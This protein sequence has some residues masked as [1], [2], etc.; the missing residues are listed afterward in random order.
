[1]I[2]DTFSTSLDTSLS[3][4][5]VV[6]AINAVAAQTG[7]VAT[8]TGDDNLGVTLTSSDGRNIDLTVTGILSNSLGLKNSASTVYVGSYSLY[9][10]DSSDITIG[11]ATGDVGTNA[12]TIERNSGLQIG[13]Y[14]ADTALFSSGNR[15]TTTA[16]APPDDSTTSG[17]LRSN[18]LI[19]N[20]VAIAAGVSTD[21]S[22]TWEGLVAADGTDIL[23]GTATTRAASA[24]AIAG[25]INRASA[26]TGVN[27]T[28]AANVIR[29]TGFAATG[30]AVTGHGV[31]LNG[32]SFRV[33]ATSVDQVID[34]FNDFKDQTGVVASRFGDGMQLVANDGRTISIATSASAASSLGLTG[35]TIGV[36]SV[37][38]TAVV[39]HYA[40]VNLSSDKSFEIKAGAGGN[41]NL[42]LLGFRQ[43]TYGASKNGMKI[44]DVDVS[45]AAGAN[46]SI[47]AI[48]SAINTV[49]AAQAKSGAINNRLDVIINNLAEGSK[50]MQA[51][52]SRI[53][54]TD[55]ATETTNLAKQQIVQQAA[56]AMLAQANQ[57]AQGVLSLLK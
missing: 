17:L 49:S 33:A 18:S 21:D 16:A 25:A 23:G 13:T 3:R 54:D 42:E 46:Q 22:S 32:V 9:T 50:N 53:L 56:T 52:R 29:G 43:G 27:A 34:R 8:D 7:V 35:V 41:T 44:A 30:I 15:I 24:I 2:T 14:K 36:E 55:Y 26:L 38:A 20:G 19:I 51:S 10:L 6:S 31:F 47:V 40:S 1:V 28:V 45:S 5:T 48:D 57:S 37:T 39:A 4:K 11:Q 12:A